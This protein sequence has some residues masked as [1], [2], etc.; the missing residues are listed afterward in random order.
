MLQ[1]GP[2]KPAGSPLAKML[3]MVPP[4]DGG[5]L[6]GAGAPGAGLPPP[7]GP[8]F[9]VEKVSPPIA[10]YRDA[11]QGPFMCSNCH[12]F[13]GGTCEVVS[14]PIDPNGMCNLF[15]SGGGSDEENGDAGDAG[16]DAVGGG[17]PLA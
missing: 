3:P 11:K 1:I 13:T 16:D 17:T 4:P 7:N 15:D 6:P 12:H 14:G 5:G 10:V 2:D 9:D 8:K